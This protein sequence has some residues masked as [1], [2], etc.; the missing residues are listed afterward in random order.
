M[1][2]LHSE[3]LSVGI[4]P[5]VP[6]VVLAQG[7]RGGPQAELSRLL[8]GCEIVNDDETIAR[9]A[10]RACALAQTNDVV[11]AIVVVTAIA[12]ASLVITS[13]KKDLSAL[14]KAVGANVGIHVV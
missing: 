7:W 2:A 11:D 8:K 10:G 4:V 1:W 5:T 6:A 14:C 12:N 13:D 9:A 3:I